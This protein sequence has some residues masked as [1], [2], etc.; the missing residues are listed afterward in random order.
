MSKN[1]ISKIIHYCWFGRGEKPEIVKKCISSWK[2]NLKDYEIKEWNEDSFDINSNNFV[3]EAYD[4]NKYAFV[5][6]YVRVYALYNYGGIYLDTD[7]E[8]IQSFDKYLD[9]ESFW[10]FEVGN[11][12]AT[13]T[14]GAVKGN[15]F[16]KR[17]LDFYDGKTFLNEDGSFNVITNVKI[18]SKIFQDLGVKLDG[19]YQEIDKMGVIYPLEIFSPYDYR[20]YEDL[21]NEDTVC[22]HHYYKSWL[23][24]NQ[25]VRQYLKKNF[26]KLF[27]SSLIKRRDKSI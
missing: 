22:I 9:N 3:R 11:Y 2:K 13:S 18:V 21:R 20:Y 14:I 19:K 27:G 23:P 1:R 4:N 7:V 10:G 15:K 12:V 16:I 25:K 26:I 8:V 6:D 17:F 5:S 24:L